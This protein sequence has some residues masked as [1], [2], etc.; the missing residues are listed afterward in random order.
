VILVV[1]LALAQHAAQDI[2]FI[3]ESATILVQLRL[4]FLAQIVQIV[5]VI[6]IPAVIQPH[7]QS[8]A[9]VITSTKT[10]VITLVQSPLT[11]LE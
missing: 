3:M 9:Q 10:S 1:I 11:L 6:A 4:I 5:P 7:V 8:A 2:I